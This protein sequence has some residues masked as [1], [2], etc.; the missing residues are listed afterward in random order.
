MFILLSR[1][2]DDDQ[3]M[4][5]RVAVASRRARVR[6]TASRRRVYGSHGDWREDERNDDGRNWRDGSDGDGCDRSDGGGWNG[7]HGD[8]R[9]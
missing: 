8:W 5:V 7:S 6:P 9:T 3:G 1:D 4:C 2:A